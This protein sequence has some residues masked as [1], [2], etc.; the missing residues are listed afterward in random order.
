V[1]AARRIACLAGSAESGAADRPGQRSGGAPRAL[2]RRGG[3]QRA[4]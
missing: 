1:T 3:A 2:P 4:V